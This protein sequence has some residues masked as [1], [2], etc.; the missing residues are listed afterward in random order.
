M[1]AGVEFES[2]VLDEH[3]RKA[4][5][6]RPIAHLCLNGVDALLG[7]VRPRLVIIC[8]EPGAG[9]T[10]LAH[11]LADGLAQGGRPVLFYSFEI[12]AP[13]LVGKSLVRLSDGTL[14]VA[15]LAGND[16]DRWADQ[17]RRAAERYRSE[18]AP[19]IA[20]IERPSDPVEIGA[21]VGICE[22]E[23]GIKPAVFVD[24]VQLLPTQADQMAADERLAIKASVAGLRRI[25]NSHEVPVFAISSINRT[26]YGKA[27]AGLDSL[28]GS[29]AVEYAS[30]QIVYLAVDGK[31][32]ERRENL[33]KPQRPVTATLLKNR[34]GA[35]G[36]VRLVFDA[37]HACFREAE[38]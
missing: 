15:S 12:A 1:T 27:V 34:Y 22:R 2:A 26:S 24:Y 11:Q 21:L 36:S 29:S 35:T 18:I 25:V 38:R 31:G 5:S 30:D 37:E 32:E 16:T 3:L 13:P 33:A 20:I 23:T 8:G 7:G 4:L 28:G 19:R 6:D 10:T 17:A 9:K 14:N